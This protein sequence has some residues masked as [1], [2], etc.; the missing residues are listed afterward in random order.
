M[1]GALGPAHLQR[2]EV[3][4]VGA[5]VGTQV[6]RVPKSP[7]LVAG[8]ALEAAGRGTGAGQFVAEG[9]AVIDG[10]LFVYV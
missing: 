8:I 9:A 5:P 3:I 6:A 1:S 7:F 2:D 4:P 10:Y